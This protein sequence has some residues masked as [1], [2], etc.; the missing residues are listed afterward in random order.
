MRSLYLI[1]VLPP[2]HLSEQIDDIRKECAERYDVKAALKP[3]VH[4][5]L[6]RPFFLDTERENWLIKLLLPATGQPPFHQEIENFDSF[7]MHV[8][9]LCAIKNA[10]ITALQRCISS[11]INRN[12]IDPKEVKG[13]TLFRP[14]ITIAYRDIPPEVFPVMWEEYKNRKFKRNFMVESFSLLKHDGKRWNLLCEFRLK[15]TDILTLF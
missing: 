11:V 9:F 7:N 14:H 15:P 12:K 10:S 1:A 5:T 4:I 13:N 8:V 6:F 3:P 2:A